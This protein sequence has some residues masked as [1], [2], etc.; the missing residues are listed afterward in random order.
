MSGVRLTLE[1]KAF[2]AS[3]DIDVK[4]NAKAFQKNLNWDEIGV[5]GYAGGFTAKS[6]NGTCPPLAQI[7]VYVDE[8]H[9]YYIKSSKHGRVLLRASNPTK[10]IELA[11]GYL[12]NPYVEKVVLTADKL[13]PSNFMPKTTARKSVKAKVVVVAPRVLPQAA[14]KQVFGGEPMIAATPIVQGK[15]NIGFASL[16]LV[17]IVVLERRKDG[18]SVA[19]IEVRNYQGKCVLPTR[20]GM[21]LVVSTDAKASNLED[22]IKEELKRN[23]SADLVI[24]L[25][26]STRGAGTYRASNKPAKKA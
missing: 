25:D 7:A 13:A 4:M 18:S 16:P 21:G 24:S 14:S 9:R 12:N 15:F 20:D 8:K 2:Q 26:P 3:H 1:Q 5:I 11:R 22:K 10:A 19:S 17:R 6:T 23:P